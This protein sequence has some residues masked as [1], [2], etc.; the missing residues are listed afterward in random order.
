M[1]QRTLKN[2]ISI[3]GIGLH[4]GNTVTL[5]LSPAP[6]DTGVVFRVHHNGK[7]T[8]ITPRP[9]LVQAT[10][11]ATTLGIQEASVA[12]VEHLLAAIMGYAI[13]NI[14]VDVVGGEIPI[15]D[16][17][18]APFIILFNNAGIV[19]Q[20]KKR[21]VAKVKKAY[22]LEVEG[23]AISVKP[24]DAFIIDY[25][26]CF[27]HPLIRTQHFVFT[28]TPENFDAISR[29][30]TFGFLREIEF[31][32]SKNLA[33]GGSLDNAIVLDQDNILNKEGLR[34]QDEFVRHKV[35]DFIGD[36]GML[37]TPVCGHFTLYCSG[38]TL[39]NQF[40]QHLYSNQEAYLD[41]T[42]LTTT[43]KSVAPLLTPV[44]SV[45]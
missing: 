9:D 1:K 31:L 23:K 42:T 38:H 22:T 36:M 2:S 8:H 45:A 18:A 10:S 37:G 33:L 43:Q 17:S 34:F 4:S 28:V 26:I 24:A 13:D 29:A 25:T 20:R 21:T 40:L 39:N 19:T 41:Y 44:P 11:L 6:V 12:T 32:R 16:G 3:S 15:L 5:T 14:Y 30:R 7:V 35:L 27:S